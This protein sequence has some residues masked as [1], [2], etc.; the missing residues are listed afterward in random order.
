MTALAV[1]DWPLASNPYM[2]KRLSK[3]NPYLIRAEQYFADLV[4]RAYARN[5]KV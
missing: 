5:Y 2:P 1:A 4:L 3:V